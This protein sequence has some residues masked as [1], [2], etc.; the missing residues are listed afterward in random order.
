[1]FAELADGLRCRFC[2]V[3]EQF[4]H[5]VRTEQAGFVE[6]ALDQ[7]YAKVAQLVP[8]RCIEGACDYGGLRKMLIRQFDDLQRLFAVS[9][10]ASNAFK[11]AA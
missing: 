2:R 7:L 6:F 1:M 4:E 3:A 9:R 11:F 10:R 8:V 5:A